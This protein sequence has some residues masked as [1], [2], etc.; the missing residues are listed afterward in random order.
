MAE[1]EGDVTDEEGVIRVSEI[2]LRYR[3][4]IPAGTQDKVQR[5][6]ETYASRCPA[7]L[8]VKD[9]IAVSWTADVEEE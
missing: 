4:K 1:V 7:Y 2:R 5:A 9:C 3:L 8:T 6:L